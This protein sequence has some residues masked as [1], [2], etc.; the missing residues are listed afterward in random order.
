MSGSE[1]E[2]TAGGAVEF[3]D[4]AWRDARCEASIAFPGLPEHVKT[5]RTFVGRVLGQGHPC[6]E[7]AV[8]LAS[9][10]VTNSVQHSDSAGPEGTIGVTVSGT[11]TSVT[12]EVA[13]AGGATV[14]QVHPGE[15]LDEE[16][17]RGLQLVAALADEWDS[18]ENAAGRVTWYTVTAR[19][20]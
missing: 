17:G 7:L 14:P 9:E 5:A 16:G 13:D 1:A 4:I 11:L 18:Q 10:L 3:G 8:Q 15:D 19:F 12:V 6:G 20:P 2:V